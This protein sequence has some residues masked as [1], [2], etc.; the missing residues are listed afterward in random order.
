VPFLFYRDKW[1]IKIMSLDSL[2]TGKTI[3]LTKVS[4]LLAKKDDDYPD[5]QWTLRYCLE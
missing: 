1:T 4:Q 3:S 5:L 2:H